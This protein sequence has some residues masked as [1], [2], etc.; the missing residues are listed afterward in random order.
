MTIQL[1]EAIDLAESLSMAEKLELLK[2]L[3][4]IIQ[5]AH[6]LKNQSH[7]NSNDA[8]LRF[9]PESFRRSWEQAVTRRTLPLCALWNEND[10]E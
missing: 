2:T 4:L 7:S 8:D 9:S 3:S 5:E 1:Q 10:V 6:A